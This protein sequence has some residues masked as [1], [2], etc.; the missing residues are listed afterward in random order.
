MQ[1][2]VDGPG[3]G[4]GEGRIGRRDFICLG[5][6]GLL[7]GGALPAGGEV[8]DSAPGLRSLRTGARPPRSFR[9]LT[10]EHGIST[11]RNIQR[12]TGCTRPRRSTSRGL[13]AKC[14]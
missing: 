10:D 5:A 11:R 13:G 6:A 2:L 9:R 7:A 8:K 1:S 14:R 12:A 4:A 3:T